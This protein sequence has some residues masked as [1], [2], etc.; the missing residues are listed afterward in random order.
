MNTAGTD[1][2]FY[3]TGSQIATFQNGNLGIATTTPWGLLSV[4]SN[5]LTGGAPSFVIGSS[6]ATSLIVTN[7]GNVGIGTSTPWG[8]LTVVGGDHSFP[9]FLV[10]TTSNNGPGQRALFSV[11]STTTGALDYARV[12]IGGTSTPW[13]TGGP[14][15][16]LIVN[17]RIYS[18]WNYIQCD[19][20]ASGAT[21]TSIAITGD[22]D[23]V[24]AGSFAF[25]SSTDGTLVPQANQYPYF[26]RLRAGVQTSLANN[27][28]ATI[29]T[30]GGLAPATT[31]PVME[32]R[33]RFAPGATASIGTSTRIVGFTDYANNSAAYGTA[34]VDGAYFTA[35][36]SGKWA[37]IVRTNSV[38]NYVQTS[39][40]TSTTFQRL[41][42]ELSSSTAI[43]LIN[44]N[45]VASIAPG[46]APRVPLLPMI[47]VAG[48]SATAG[49]VNTNDLDVAYIKVW[50]DDPLEDA[51]ASDV[52][53]EALEELLGPED[54]IPPDLIRG[55]DIAEE[56]LA[57]PP[58]DFVEGM[59]VSNATTSDRGVVA[60]SSRRYDS[61]LM[62]VVSTSPHTVLGEHGTSTIRV[63]MTGRVPVIVSLE[64]GA[65][66]KG[67]SVTAS[68]LSGIGMKARRP[69]AIV[70]KA[71]ES[72]D[73]QAGI[74]YCDPELKDEL[75]LHGVP[76]AEDGCFARILIV[77]DSDFNMGI[78][79]VV[80]DITAEIATFAQAMDELANAAFEKGAELTKIVIGQ[81]VAKIAIVEKLFVKETHTE[82]LCV[83]DGGGETC[84]TKAQLDALLAG[85]GVASL[86]PPPNAPS[87]PAPEGS[88]TSTPP[89]PPQEESP[90]MEEEPPPEGEGS[91]SSTPLVS[92]PPDEPPAETPPDSGTTSDQ[93]SDGYGAGEPSTEEYSSQTAVSSPSS[94]SEETL[95]PEPE[96][97]SSELSAEPA[98]PEAADT[99]E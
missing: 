60:K 78:G 66:T 50:V 10:A 48:S 17:G 42:I 73:P 69:G 68:S 23:N 31:S 51:F 67:D 45:V 62:G 92:P 49:Q 47:L 34:P 88:A 21:S 71:L 79:D 80:Q 26:A 96:P 86:L 28:A 83:G 38:Q 35:T 41:R 65:I 52:G 84:V 82:K 12:V 11:Y 6:T 1:I 30:L 24:C 98:P 36:T 87:P 76:V 18:T 27:D 3:D 16:Q 70:G 33:V 54:Y 61:E 99:Q 64:N 5:G 37:A 43:F 58:E 56:Y 55:A 44:G 7:G 94:S 63:A 93:N 75:A 14:R 91:A 53:G 22:T 77:I 8:K 2:D 13:G 81:I 85:A 25:D 40:S 72:F 19:F 59:L 95:A 9:S 89:G 74:R 20:T 4:N 15:D 57:G 97:T 32:A 39:I 46:Q 90:P 29:R